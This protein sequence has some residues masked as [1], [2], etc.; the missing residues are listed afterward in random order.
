MCIRA[1]GWKCRACYSSCIHFPHEWLHRGW[2]CAAC[3]RIPADWRTHEDQQKLRWQLQQRYPKIHVSVRSMFG[4][5]YLQESS[6]HVPMQFS[7]VHKVEDVVRYLRF[8][9]KLRRWQNI[10]ICKGVEMLTQETLLGTLAETT[11]KVE[12]SAARYDSTPAQLR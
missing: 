8:R 2:R 3:A 6:G 5:D 4:Q 10:D 7:A 11:G 9:L 1:R 12:L